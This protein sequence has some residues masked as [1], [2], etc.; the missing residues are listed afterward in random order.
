MFPL[1]EIAR[2]VEPM[3]LEI[4]PPEAAREAFERMSRISYDPPLTTGREELLTLKCPCCPDENEFDWHW[5]KEGGTGW[6][7]RSF[8]A[9][10]PTCKRM[11]K[12]EVRT[13]SQSEP[14]SISYSIG[15]CSSEVQ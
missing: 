14:S 5:L 4:D 6:A 9:Q 7:Q 11:V 15:V 12:H 3:S 2:L 13:K 8:Q 10:C 1:L